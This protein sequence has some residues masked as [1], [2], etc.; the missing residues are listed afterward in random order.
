MI[1]FG[2]FS[3]INNLVADHAVL[4][5]VS[6]SPYSA[7]WNAV[8]IDFDSTGKAT[9]RKGYTKKYSS[10]GLVGSFSCSKGTFIIEHGSL[11]SINTLTW[12]TTTIASGI[13]G[14]EF[15]FF[16][17]NGTLYFSDGIKNLKI[18]ESLA[19][20]WGISVPP[21]PVISASPGTLGPGMYMCCYTYV[22]AEGRESGASDISFITPTVE[23]SLSFFNLPS[24]PD[25]KV[26]ATRIYL[27]TAN[28][29][30]FFQCAEVSRGVTTA[31]VILDFDSGKQLETQFMSG[32]PPGRI[33]RN[34]KGRM[35]VAKGSCVYF[36][37]PFSPDLF[38]TLGKGRFL[39]SQDVT[40]VE[41]VADGLWIVAD[42]TYFFSG[43][44]L[45][46]KTIL[47]YGAV[48]GTSKKL[49]N[50]GE[51]LWFTLRGFVLAGNGGEIKNIQEGRVAP[52]Y[53]ETEGSTLIREFD[54]KRQAI[55]SLVNP[56]MSPRANKTW[57][58]T[59]TIR[60]Q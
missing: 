6:D 4:Q 49:E 33:I 23:S 57:L 12:A 30:T 48:F 7:V 9:R 22:D 42:K 11:K 31:S 8:N 34:Y 44:D 59:E 10:S 29:D 56:I 2:P 26:V 19:V 55:V 54:G 50:S 47:E 24:S 32:P 37:E 20:L 28:G 53:S 16:E 45:Q 46:R 25:E 43:E 1:Q 13:T 21:A 17:H 14:L 41:P 18:T 38:S 52:D 39:F 3:G 15:A 35:L 58:D 27:T 40:V 60:R 5:K 51:V 36:G